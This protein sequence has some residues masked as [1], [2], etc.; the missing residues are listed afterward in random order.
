MSAAMFNL[1]PG[2]INTHKVCHALCRGDCVAGKHSFFYLVMNLTGHRA[3]DHICPSKDASD[4]DC[5]MA[6]LRYVRVYMYVKRA[7]KDKWVASSIADRTPF[8]FAVITNCVNGGEQRNLVIKFDTKYL[9]EVEGYTCV[10][11]IKIVDD[12]FASTSFKVESDAR[13]D[14]NWA[15]LYDMTSCSGVDSALIE[16]AH[17]L[18]ALK[19]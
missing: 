11:N 3:L 5:T 17:H 12:I 1:I 2:C 9:K 15:L 16:D 10:L 4:I 8:T 19:Y 18:L 6:V 14:S 7:E 13:M